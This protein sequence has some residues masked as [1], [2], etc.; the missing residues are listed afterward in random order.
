ME[1]KLGIVTL[2]IN[3]VKPNWLD[4]YSHSEL[5]RA[6]TYRDKTFGLGNVY[7]AIQD[8]YGET[9]DKPF[10]QNVQFILLKK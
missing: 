10:I 3:N 5:T 1:S 2:Q 7:T 8:A 4:Q 6:N 9:N